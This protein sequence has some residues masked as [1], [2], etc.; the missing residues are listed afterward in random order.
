MGVTVACMAFIN[1][2]VHCVPDMNYQVAL[3][4]EFT[5]LGLMPLIEE[6][7]KGA[8]PALAEQIDAYQDNFLNVAELAREAEARVLDLRRID[9]LEREAEAARERA[10]ADAARVAEQMEQLHK[11]LLEEKFHVES[12][13]QRMEDERAAAEANVT[14]IAFELSVAKQELQAARDRIADTELELEEVRGQASTLRRLSEGTAGLQ[15]SSSSSG[16]TQPLHSVAIQV[17]PTALAEAEAAAVAAA[18]P[19]PPPAPPLPPPPPAPG[20]MAPPPPPG[21]S[22]SEATLKR[23]PIMV[24][25]R[26]PMLNWSALLESKVGDT[27]FAQVDDE[28]VLNEISF[29]EFKDAF[30]LDVGSGG[31][32]GLGSNAARSSGRQFR[33]D[34]RHK[35]PATVLDLNRA[36]NLAIAQRRVGTNVEEVVRAIGELDFHALPA[37]K[38]ELLRNEFVPTE[39]E[40]K[41]LTAQHTSG[42]SM[43]D[44]DDFLYRLSRVPRLRQKLSLLSYLDSCEEILHNVG[45]QVATVTTASGCLM[46]SER[47]RKLLAVILAY[48]NFMN[49]QRRGCAAGFKLSVLDRLLD[50]RTRDREANLM[51]Y[52]AETLE[53][54]Y[55]DVVNFMDDLVGLEQASKVSLQALELDVVAVERTARAVTEE[56]EHDATHPT[57]LSFRDEQMARVERVREDY[58]QAKQKFLKV[59]SYFAEEQAT[60]PS[61]FFGMFLRLGQALQV[62]RRE[63]V[64]RA[65]RLRREREEAER[66]AAEQRRILVEDADEPQMTEERLPRKSAVGLRSEVGDGDI[67]TIISSMKTSAFRRPGV[68]HKRELGQADHLSSYA[69]SRPWLK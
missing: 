25:V 50:M 31:G 43:A 18:A 37:E 21:G 68:E 44:M 6:L 15:T 60:E 8:S 10:R 38:A 36:R 33:T 28:A 64:E 29:D 54:K 13:G 4:E 65:E 19:A 52:I 24:D 45:P 59:T 56:L 34:T 14:R 41:L 27:V 40:L 55:P 42:R 46:K 11:E 35:G 62:A 20:M 22:S 47:L 53:R 39:D 16:Y 9:E 49:S 17:D 61:T 51:H 63:N 23:R 32:H 66:R 69:A 3:Q 67:D 48:G 30:R 1:V 7:A 2:V 58:N 12:L 57:L 5:Q 26:L